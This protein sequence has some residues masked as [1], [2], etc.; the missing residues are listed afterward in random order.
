MVVSPLKVPHRLSVLGPK[1]QTIDG[2]LVK[3]IDLTI[4]NDQGVNISAM[5]FYSP[6]IPNPDLVLYLH[7]NGGSKTEALDLVKC[8]TKFGFG[9]AAFDFVGCG[10]S[11]DGYLTYGIQE[12]A[13]VRRVLYE[14]KKHLSYRKLTLWGRSMGAAISILFAANYP[15]E[16]SSLVLDVPFCTLDGIVKRAAYR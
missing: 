9:V 13:D 1:E 12:M 11:G 6:E 5:L 14:I 8:V 2:K 10:N 7:G 16:V 4:P 3:R 15:N